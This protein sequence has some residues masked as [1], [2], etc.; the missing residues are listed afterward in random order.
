MNGRMPLVSVMAEVEKSSADEPGAPIA[1]DQ[2][3][4]E[5]I[6]LSRSGPKV[7][8]L[9][10]AG[11]VFLCGFFL[12]K[13]NADRRFSGSA[14]QPSKVMV[15]DVLAGNVGL[16]TYVALEAEPLM[17]HA[18]RSTTAKGSLGL[19]IA[20]ARATAERLW[21]VVS[22]DGWEAPPQ[23]VYVGRLRKLED[24]PFAPSVAAFADEHPRLVF[25]T[26]AMIRSGIATNKVKTVSGDEFSVADADRVAF[27]IV[28]PNAAVIV[29][30]TNERLPNAAAWQKELERA[31]I[32]FIA[33]PAGAP[34]ATTEQV[35]FDVT[36]PDAVATLTSKL[37]AA[38]LFARVDPVTRHYDTT[39][40]ALKAS[41]PAGFT[42]GATT[43]PDPQIDLIGLYV[44]RGIPS[45][46][47]ALITGERPDDYWFVLPVTVVLGLV[48][49]L[50]AWAL[51]RAVKRDLLPTPSR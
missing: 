4:P 35:R 19:R 43:I 10:A 34:Q 28:D 33:P 13:M 17:S 7:R 47:Y 12:W 40:A 36:L 27:D 11:L 3:D 39:W 1:K 22:G 49:L 42:I 37:E 20:P 48:G 30:T 32:G 15:S 29:G 21:L 9:T 14:S 46:A 26:A 41:G 51:V 44:A 23:G 24:L 16:D 38:N 5:L 8:V 50:S 2:V 25:A 6:D 18:I 31:Q 45:G